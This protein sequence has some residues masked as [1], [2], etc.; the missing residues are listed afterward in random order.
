MSP[1]VG[2]ALSVLFEGKI[3]YSRHTQRILHILSSSVLARK[4]I[5]NIRRCDSVTMV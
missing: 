4:N 3:D 2:E 5:N 1:A